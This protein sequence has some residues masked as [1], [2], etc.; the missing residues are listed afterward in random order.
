MDAERRFSDK[1]VKA[2]LARAVEYAQPAAEDRPATRQGTTAAELE[3]IAAEAGLPAEAL[4]RA[5]A[6]LDSPTRRDSTALRRALGCEIH[7]AETGLEKAPTRQELERLLMILPD[8]ARLPGSGSVADDSLIWRSEYTSQNS[9]GIKRRV[10]ISP[11]SGGGALVKVEVDP[12]LAGV[13]AYVGLVVG[14]GIT[15]ISV[16]LPIGLAVLHSP[17]FAILTSLGAFILSF[18]GARG[19]MALVT[20]SIRAKARQGLAAA[21]PGP[22]GGKRAAASAAARRDYFTLA[23]SA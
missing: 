23:E 5:L 17:A 7:V 14:L 13:G 15:A 19:I 22:P 12:S 20:R 18:L 4:R 10:E 1:E 11:K 21:A 16:A 6:E 2:L 3:R 8:I 9:S